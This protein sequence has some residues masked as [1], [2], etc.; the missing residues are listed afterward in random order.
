MATSF[1]SKTAALLSLALL[2]SVPALRAQQTNLIGNPGFERSIRSFSPWGGVSS[3][4][5]LE[6][7]TNEADILAQVG[8]VAPSKMP[9]SISAGDLNGDG[10]PDIAAMDGLGYLKIYFNSGTKTEPKFSTPEYTSLFLNPLPLMRPVNRQVVNVHGSQGTQRI[11]LADVTKTGKLDLLIGTYGGTLHFIPNSGGPARPDFRNPARPEQALVK[12]GSRI[13]ANILAPHAVD[14]NKDG[15]PDIL[16]GE[17]SYSANSIHI[18]LGKK[19]GQPA[20]EDAD[21]HVLAWGMGL[22]QLSP[23]VVDWNN[24]G[25]PDLLVTERG[26]RVALYLNSGAPWKP[27]DTLPFHSLLTVDGAPPAGLPPGTDT[28]K[29]DPLDFLKATNLVS[30]GGIS[31]ISSADFNGDGLFDLVFGKRSGRIAIALN[32]GQSGQP[33]FGQPEDI[34]STVQAEMIFAPSSWTISTGEQRG[35]FLAYASAIK[36]DANPAIAPA[37]GTSSLVV[38]YAPAKYTI[39][40]LPAYPRPAARDTETVIYSPNYFEV[41]QTLGTPLQVGKTYTLTF[42]ARG[43]QVSAA[44]ATLQFRGL[45]QLG[46]D[47][48]VRGDR[49]AV[50]KELNKA[51]ETQKLPETF[52][53]GSN[54][55]EVRK[56][57]AIKFENKDL[58][59]LEKTTGAELRISFLLVPGTG[60]IA[61]DDFKLVEKQ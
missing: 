26:G 50:K 7:P 23:C 16:V 12:T 1:L 14:W 22:E 6:S 24:D 43:A 59:T 10:L 28:A 15:R 48:I 57:F 58:N 46:E 20:F 13:W 39:L 27:G 9:V 49:G 34:K 51:E 32:K 25:H 21:R 33:K 52:S 17:G 55:S 3:S 40:P 4:G 30:T 56:D 31:T 2:A 54:W 60:Q 36:A 11:H 5:L 38:G 29:P 41:T 45:K 44:T 61:L 19:M 47:R 18:L 42:K 35:N 8:G 37:E 53:P